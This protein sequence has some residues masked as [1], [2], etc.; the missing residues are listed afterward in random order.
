MSAEAQA[1][2]AAVA[3]SSAAATAAD[4]D[5]ND[6]TTTTSTTITTTTRS[7]SHILADG[8]F[9]H[10]P[11]PTAAERVRFFERSIAR[12][13]LL[14]DD[15][16]PGKDD[17]EEKEDTDKEGEEQEQAQQQIHPL[18]LASARLQASGIS[19]LNR[20]IN[21]YTLVSTGD[22]F[23]LSNIVSSEQQ[24]QQQQQQDGGATTAAQQ[25]GGS[26]STGDKP[27]TTASDSGT[28]AAP[29]TTTTTSTIAT[30]HAADETAAVRHAAAAAFVLKRTR[31]QYESAACTLRTHGRRVRAAVVAQS[32]TDHRWRQLRCQ[33]RLQAP[34][35]GSRALPHATRPTE[36]V[37]ASVDVYGGSGTTA[38]ATGSTNTTTTATTAGRLARRVPRYATLEL[39]DEYNVRAPG[40]LPQWMERHGLAPLDGDGDVVESSNNSNNQKTNKDNDDDNNDGME[41]DQ[42]EVDNEE[43]EDK[44][45]AATTSAAP[46][47]SS[48]SSKSTTACWT[49]AEPFAMADPA[50]G[51][52][53]ADFDPAKVAMLTLQFDIEKPSTGFCQSACLEPISSTTSTATTTA[54]NTT[55]SKD[56]QHQHQQ[57]QD[58]DEQLLVAL[59]HSLF[60]AKL[61]ESI[62]RELAPDTEDIGR[63]RTTAKAQSAVWLSGESEENFLPAL[64]L[65]MKGGG[66]DHNSSSSKTNNNTSVSDGGG[67]APLCVVHVH[68]GDVK[69]LLDREYSL[70]VRLVEADEKAQ[71]AASRDATN[72]KSNSDDTSG[73]QTP[74]QLRTLCQA[75]LLH[76]QERHHRHSVDAA[77][78]L[79][80]QQKSDE[81][82]L[83]EL[84]KKNP[85]ITTLPPQRRDTSITS[86][87]IL[88]SCVS[89]GAKMLFERR[90]R[91]TLRSVDQWVK[92]QTAA[93]NGEGLT[94]E[95]L[96]L[97]VFDLYAQFAVSFGSEW[98]IDVNM[99]GDELVVTQFTAVADGGA[100]RKVK[101]HTAAEFELYLKMALGRVLRS[102]TTTTTTI[103]TNT[104]Q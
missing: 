10:L 92:A 38:A 89:L 27:Q 61:F 70:R 39:R 68:E 18:A 91:Q 103:T 86:P 32:V 21:L 52:L 22:Y 69:V 78:N 11:P 98:S 36:V 60:C 28:P 99:V 96:S 59:Q 62:R 87:R 13:G 50:L 44:K 54:T 71:A 12:H 64:S 23:G 29:T 67:L 57:H 9:V 17:E 42:K 3:P 37:A 20:A 88:Q 53:D 35:H 102:T 58:D 31:A 41:I 94:V 76:A 34:E 6:V 7:P 30:E 8:T 81:E 95:W 24:Q 77:A 19:E 100:Y 80:R 47:S 5:A 83:L 82:K 79:R 55:T 85:N 33:W 72:D 51:K 2:V 46:S 48:P 66:D 97:S 14:R 45:P 65:M 49:R 40:Q 90:I 101:F 15:L 63:V 84:M 104:T 56:E 16:A 43:K 25:D 74:G 1:Q 73:S 75:L 4:A 26:S 93:T